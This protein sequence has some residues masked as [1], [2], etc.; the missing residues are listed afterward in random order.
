MRRVLFQ[1]VHP[2]PL[3]SRANRMVLDAVREQL[4]NVTV[5][6]LYAKYPRFD[7]DVKTEQDLLL[8]HDDVFFQHPFY[9]YSMPPLL[10][11]WM[12]EV[13]EW[14]FAYGPEG[15]RLRGKGF[16]LSLTTGGSQDAY[17]SD[18]V[19]RFSIESFFPSYD[20]TAHL[21][22]M[23]WHRPLVLFHAGKASD[24]DLK[25]HARRVVSYIKNLQEC[26]APCAA[27]T[28]GEGLRRDD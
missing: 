2:T 10:K 12:D 15:N 24:E 6:D 9:W 22:G 18:G 11:L 21:C 1:F 20:Q 7:V 16:H 8:E 3:R 14:N 23:K 19:N 17:K 13:L 5:S 26:D 25:V 4:P 27:D 28:E